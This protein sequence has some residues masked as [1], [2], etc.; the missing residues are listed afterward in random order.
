MPVDPKRK[1]WAACGVCTACLATDCGD[2]INCMDKSK[3]G[4]QGVRKQSCIMRRCVRMNG[5]GSSSST[6][7][8]AGSST[9][10]SGPGS[11][12]G[13]MEPSPIRQKTDSEQALFWAAVSGCMALTGQGTGGSDD[14]S[15][16]TQ[17]HP[18]R[19]SRDSGSSSPRSPSHSFTDS[20]RDGFL[21]RDHHDVPRSRATWGALR[22][23]GLTNAESFCG[24]LSSL[25]A[26]DKTL[27]SQPIALRALQKA[28]VG[29]SNSPLSF[30][31]SLENPAI[32]P[33]LTT[34]L[35]AAAGLPASELARARL[36]PVG[37]SGGGY[38]SYAS[39][40]STAG[41]PP[42]SSLAAEPRVVGSSSPPN[43]SSMS[44]GLP[45]RPMTSG[46]GLNGTA[47]GYTGNALPT[48][49]NLVAQSEM[50]ANESRHFAQP[51]SAAPRVAQRHEA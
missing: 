8:A 48:L 16:I 49:L 31:S 32:Q 5:G 29:D 50:L 36:T 46:L 40:Y 2:C 33:H 23:D 24:K 9:S 34:S 6:S 27:A 43:T 13:D 28:G 25:L 35:A 4:G 17:G 22:G 14:D 41:L 38:S 15:A 26:L 12:R 3:F 1:R 45:R 39:R 51:I 18:G 42:S 7:T 19:T 37:E 30:A 44:A 11:E 10:S 47:E 20:D 21:S